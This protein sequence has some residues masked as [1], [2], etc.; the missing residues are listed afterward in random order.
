MG[1]AI[2]IVFVLSLALLLV[3]VPILLVLRWDRADPRRWALVVR[4]AGATLV[5]LPGPPDTRPKSDDQAP[6]IPPWLWR[7]IDWLIAKWK[8]SRGASPRGG[9]SS[10]PLGAFGFLLE[11][12]LVRP[13]KGLRLEIGGIDPATLAALHGL[14]LSAR[15]LVPGGD[16]LR[17]HPVWTV[18][19]PR[20]RLV[21]SLRVSVAG[22]FGGLAKVVARG[23]FGVRRADSPSSS[24]APQST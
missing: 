3:P 19:E 23:L 15:P 2:A 12:L 8:K 18:F 21:W 14:F 20:F 6:A 13:T 17:F 4:L 16:T 24:E 9:R 10:D 5:R 22:L 7:I 11:A 1:T